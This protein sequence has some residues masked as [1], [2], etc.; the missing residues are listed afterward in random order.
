MLSRPGAFGAGTAGPLE[1]AAP[2][3]L[4]VPAA[5][6]RPAAA[7]V[8]P[9]GRRDPGAVL[10]GRPRASAGA[11]AGDAVGGLQ[12]DAEGGAA[13]VTE[14]AAVEVEAAAAQVGEDGG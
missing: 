2:L 4:A 10:A 14:D 13:A 1:E 6:Q 5:W 12:R 7:A 8:G 9:P 11:A 3:G